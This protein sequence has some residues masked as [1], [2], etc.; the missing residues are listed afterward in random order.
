MPNI[1][2][3]YL[4]RD[5]SNYKHFGYVIFFNLDNLSLDEV[6]KLIE[7]RLIYDTWFYTHEWNLPDL[8]PNYFDIDNDPTWHEFEKIEFT[9]ERATRLLRSIL[10]RASRSQ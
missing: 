3:S 9:D 2:F 8:R 10:P 6:A 7:A 4:Y 1:K 5:S